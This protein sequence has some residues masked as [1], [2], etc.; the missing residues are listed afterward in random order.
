MFERFSQKLQFQAGTA[1]NGRLREKQQAPQFCSLPAKNPK[2]MQKN[3]PLIGMQ[4]VLVHG[5][6][7][8]ERGEQGCLQQEVQRL[9]AVAT[10]SLHASC[11]EQPCLTAHPPCPLPDI[12]SVPFPLLLPSPPAPILQDSLF[13]GKLFFFFFCRESVKI[14]EAAAWVWPKNMA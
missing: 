5:G 9:Q 2:Q 4:R 10:C 8:V 13:P 14:A 3:L 6:V 11:Y 7:G 1:K 12:L